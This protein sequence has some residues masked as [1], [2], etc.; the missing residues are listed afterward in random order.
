MYVAVHISYVE[1]FENMF[2]SLFA[3]SWL[4]RTDTMTFPKKARICSVVPDASYAQTKKLC[5][6]Q[7]G[8]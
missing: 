7:L 8:K 2:Y 3:T 4:Q 1:Y 5:D 6:I